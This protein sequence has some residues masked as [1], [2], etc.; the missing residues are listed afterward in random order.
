MNAAEIEITKEEFLSMC[1]EFGGP[2]TLQYWTDLLSDDFLHVKK[3]EWRFVVSG[4]NK[5]I[6]PKILLDVATRVDSKTIVAFFATEEEVR[7]RYGN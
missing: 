5:P 2:N 4:E 3:E 1:S 6:P 7:S